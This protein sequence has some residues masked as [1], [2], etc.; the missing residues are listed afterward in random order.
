VETNR[1][2]L[3][4]VVDDEV[5]VRRFVRALL[6]QAGHTV[7]E[8]ACGDDALA[9]LRD[10]APLPEL[11][12]TD[13]VMPGMNGIAL[14]A[15]AHKLAPNLHV[16][17]MSGFTQDYASELTGSVCLSKP[18]KPAELLSTVHSALALKA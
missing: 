2:F 10:Q 3:I 11:M 8:A 14:A 6:E 15:R 4:L 17:F 13:I 9:L 7:L 18:F 1:T 16:V 5:T 12:L